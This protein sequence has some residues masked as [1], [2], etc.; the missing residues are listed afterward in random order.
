MLSHR[1]GLLHSCGFYFAALLIKIYFT[2]TVFYESEQRTV[3]FDKLK[4]ACEVF[5]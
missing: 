1:G 5:S 4:E 3:L 2:F